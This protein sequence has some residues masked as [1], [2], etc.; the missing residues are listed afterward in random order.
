MGDGGRVLE[1]L[2]LYA[3]LGYTS[4]EQLDTTALRAAS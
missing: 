2:Q 4:L 1:E 3:N